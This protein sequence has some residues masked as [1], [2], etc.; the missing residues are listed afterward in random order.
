MI[1]DYDMDS[2]IGHGR[3]YPTGLEHSDK[4]MLLPAFWMRVRGLMLMKS[5]LHGFHPI[6]VQLVKW[7]HWMNHQRWNIQLSEK[8][9]KAN[10]L[11]AIF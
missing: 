8:Q 4:M 7:L 6:D 2:T 10:W 3:G 5:I 11:L 1:T 9:K